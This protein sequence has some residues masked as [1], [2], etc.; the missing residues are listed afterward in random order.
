[1][2]PDWKKKIVIGGMSTALG[3]SSASTAHD[4]MSVQEH[5]VK[6]MGSEKAASEQKTAQ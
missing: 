1:M 2:H 5:E 3:G 4:E 6:I